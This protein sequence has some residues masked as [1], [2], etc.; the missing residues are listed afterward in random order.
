VAT[1]VTRPTTFD[2]DPGTAPLPT[3][4]PSSFS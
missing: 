4:P 1:V 2:A 3:P